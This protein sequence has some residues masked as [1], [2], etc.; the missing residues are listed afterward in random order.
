MVTFVGTQPNKCR[1]KIANAEYVAL[2]N[3]CMYIIS[4]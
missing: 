1:D 2:D 4:L 3:Q